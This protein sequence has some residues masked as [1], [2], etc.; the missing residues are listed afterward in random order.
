[1]GRINAELLVMEGKTALWLSIILVS[2]LF[3]LFCFVQFCSV[4]FVVYL[5]C[6]VKSLKLMFRLFVPVNILNFM[7]ATICDFK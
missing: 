4:R 2:V 5:L 6:S 1:M 3:V 7:R